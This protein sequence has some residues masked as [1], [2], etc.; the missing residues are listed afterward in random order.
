MINIKKQTNIW[1][2]IL[3]EDIKCPSNQYKSHPN[4]SITL[5]RFNSSNKLNLHSSWV[6]SHSMINRHQPNLWLSNYS[7]KATM[8]SRH[9]QKV[10]HSYTINS[11]SRSMLRNRLTKRKHTKLSPNTNTALLCSLFNNSTRL[12]NQLTLILHRIH[13]THS[14][15]LIW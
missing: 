11:F 12:N 9:Q 2:L 6:S 13:G 15:L 3:E 1:R 4:S 7:S 8:I 10:R 5:S 14:K